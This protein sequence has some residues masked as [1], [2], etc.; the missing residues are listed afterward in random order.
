MTIDYKKQFKTPGGFL[1][2]SAIAFPLVISN[3]SMT[4]MMFM[5]RMFL[6]WVSPEN[7]AACIPA[8]VLLFTF[9]SLFLGISE[10]TN[11]FVASVF[12]RF[13]AKSDSP[14]NLAGYLFFDS[15][16]DYFFSFLS[17]GIKNF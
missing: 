8:G 5:D 16:R 15:R 3:A 2:F 13:K 17:F 11:T 12:W 4:I 10:Y 14:G 9:W 1:E 6:S 7:I